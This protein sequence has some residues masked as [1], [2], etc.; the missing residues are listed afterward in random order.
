MPLPANGRPRSHAQQ[1]GYRNLVPRVIDSSQ[2][3]PTFEDLSSTYSMLN[4]NLIEKPLEGESAVT[5]HL[6]A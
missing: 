4:E 6:I 5:V 1:V 3:V 2:K